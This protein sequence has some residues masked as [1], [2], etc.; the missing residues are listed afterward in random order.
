MTIVA[1][2]GTGTMGAGMAR[3]IA[4]AGHELRVWNR[5][6]ERARALSDVATVADDPAEAVRG[7][8]VVVTMLWDAGSVES[9]IKEAAAG[10]TPGTVWL[11]TSTVGLDGTGRLVGHRRHVGERTGAL[12]RAVPHPE[13]VAGRRDRAGHPGAHRARPQQSHACHGASPPQMGDSRRC[14]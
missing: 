14:R 2:L 1:L 5:T 7:A 13:L 3:T 10:L 4:A 9:V 6:P 8:E 11:Q 12:R